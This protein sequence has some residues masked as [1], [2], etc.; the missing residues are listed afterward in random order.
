MIKKLSHI[1]ISLLFSFTCMSQNMDNVVNKLIKEKPIK[2]KT[3]YWWG[4][5]WIYI[6]YKNSYV[7]SLCYYVNGS[8]FTGQPYYYGLEHNNKIIPINPNRKNRLNSETYRK[9]EHLYKKYGI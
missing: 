4:D 3:T 9:L 6:Y 2:I 5:K 1:I 8:P 7:I